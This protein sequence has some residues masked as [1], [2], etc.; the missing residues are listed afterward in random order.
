MAIT[1]E[2]LT[3]LICQ[4]LKDSASVSALVSGRV[5][6][7]TLNENETMPAIRYDLITKNSWKTLQGSGDKATSRVQIEC[8]GT[9]RLEAN[10]VAAAVKNNLDGFRGP[11]GDLNIFDCVMDNQY[12]SIDPP[13]SG[14]KHWRKRRV[15]DFLITHTEPTPTLT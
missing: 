13:T 6:P 10:A 12:D 15:L 1:D 4:R 3:F 7:D 9:T 14:S 5:R 2:D 11:L 8:Y